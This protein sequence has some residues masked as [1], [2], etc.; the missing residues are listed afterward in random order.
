MR[1]DFD[2]RGSTA[3][4]AIRDDPDALTP[5][6][7]IYTRS[8][9]PWVRLPEGARAFEAYYDMSSEWPAESL[10]RAKAAR[11]KAP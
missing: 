6:V 4:T 9:V 11:E 10:A 5:D 1:L 3:N 7:H 8:K 2:S